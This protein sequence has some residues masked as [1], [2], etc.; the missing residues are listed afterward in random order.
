MVSQTNCMAFPDKYNS[1]LI[2]ANEQTQLLDNPTSETNVPAYNLFPQ[3]VTI[4]QIQPI[5][6]ANITTDS[7]KNANYV[8]NLTDPKKKFKSPEILS[9][10]VT[11]FR[12]PEGHFIWTGLI[13]TCIS[14]CCCVL[15]LA[16]G[17]VL[18]FVVYIPSIPDKRYA[19]GNCTIINNDIS[20]QCSLNYCDYYGA[21]N[22]MYVG[23]ISNLNG[24]FIVLTGRNQTEMQIELAKNY[25]INRE[26]ICYYPISQNLPLQMKKPIT[27]G[28]VSAYMFSML[29]FYGIGI[30]SLISIVVGI[31]YGIGKCCTTYCCTGR[32]H[33]ESV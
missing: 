20:S 6:D 13:W 15:L 16:V 33:R 5:T 23:Q 17:F 10:C 12:N 11:E 14:V 27:H 9:K 21:I 8:T 22:I 18:Y 25:A 32:D 31:C 4:V 19:M 30:T 24:Q 29:I 1:D 26:I 2:D 3:T 28:N 7:L